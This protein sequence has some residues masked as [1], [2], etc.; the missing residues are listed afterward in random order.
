M[1]NPLHDDLALRTGNSQDSY[2]VSSGAPLDG[3]SLSPTSGAAASSPRKPSVF[4]GSLLRKMGGSARAVSGC[5]LPPGWQGYFDEW[6]NKPYYFNEGTGQW[7]TDLPQGWVGYWDEQFDQPYYYNEITGVCQWEF[8]AERADSARLAHV[9]ANGAGVVGGTSPVTAGAA[10]AGSGA[11]A[12][13]IPSH[14]VGSPATNPP[15]VSARDLAI[16]PTARERKKVSG[17]EWRMVILPRVLRPGTA[18]DA[19]KR[20]QTWYREEGC[21]GV[22]TAILLVFMIGFLLLIAALHCTPLL[23]VMANYREAR[24]YVFI[25]LPVSIIT[26]LGC[27][28]MIVR[29]SHALYR[30]TCGH[31]RTSDQVVQRLYKAKSRFK[32]VRM[33]EWFCSW[34]LTPGA[35]F[36]E[37]YEFGRQTVEVFLQIF[38]LYEFSIVGIQQ[39]ALAIYIAVMF[40]NAFASVLFLQRWRCSCIICMRGRAEADQAQDLVAVSRRIRKVV[41]AD[42]ICD[43]FYGTFPLF[44]TLL[45]YTQ[46]Y[47]EWGTTHIC[48]LVDHSGTT[49]EYDRAMFMQLPT[50]MFLFGGTSTFTIFVKMIT[51]FTPFF[52]ASS[53]LVEMVEFRS[54]AAHRKKV[55]H[56]RGRRGEGRGGRWRGGEERGS[57]AERFRQLP[58]PYEFPNDAR[59]ALTQL[60][61]SFSPRMLRFCWTPRFRGPKH[62]PSTQR[63][64]MPALQ[65]P[66]PATLRFKR[67][68]TAVSGEN[69]SSFENSNGRT[70]GANRESV[71]GGSVAKGRAGPQFRRNLTKMIEGDMEPAASAATGPAAGSASKLRTATVFSRSNPMLRPVTRRVLS[72]PVPPLAIV[73]FVLIIFGVCIFSWARLA[74]V[75]KLCFQEPWTNHCA[76]PSYPIFDLSLDG[77][78]CPC[79]HLTAVRA[80]SSRVNL[81]RDAYFPNAGP[82]QA[83]PYV[84][85]LWLFNCA[86]NN[87]HVAS[88]FRHLS[89]M[90]TLMLKAPTEIKGKLMLPEDVKPTRGGHLGSLYR[91]D[92]IAMS[93]ADLPS[94][95]PLLPNFKVLGLSHNTELKMVPPVV[96]KLKTLQN[97]V[98]DNIGLEE[99]PVWL[100]TNLTELRRFWANSNRIRSL[101]PEFGQLR[102]LFTFHMH[103]NNLTSLP[104]EFGRLTN[105]LR[106]GLA[107]N[108]LRSVPQII[109]AGGGEKL[110]LGA[111][112]GLR[113]L[114]I[115]GNNITRLPS[116]WREVVADQSPQAAVLSIEDV[117][118]L[119]QKRSNTLLVSM[120]NNSFPTAPGSS[121]L[122]WE[123]AMAEDDPL[124]VVLSMNASCNPGCEEYYW[125]PASLNAIQGDGRCDSTCNTKACHFDQGDCEGYFTDFTVPF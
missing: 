94:W 8:P 3:K 23:D 101:P 41:L 32:L 117:E 81:L 91:L 9:G 102:R 109:T 104:T 35:P 42:C 4:S 113:S 115:S 122:A 120:A 112:P 21:V 80:N 69:G 65:E 72:R 48:G 92:L 44:Y 118:S 54:W 61:S 1:Q 6:S 26:G 43:C 74:V 70:P 24:S 22:T 97:L 2:V 25:S 60:S 19:N 33:Y 59:L 53:R 114:D 16:S 84:Q 100:G 45:R 51:R 82:T 7:A 64:R 86:L 89:G 105:L 67:P 121:D 38:A 87:S 56:S 71:L 93:L 49:C 78:L 58:M 40:V 29:Y 103:G 31:G 46:V 28:L 15:P 47:G 85:N 12:A 123:V 13:G 17:Q 10:G 111:L 77:S 30:V 107:G 20:A 90:V 18:G 124:R 73:G 125:K 99:V 39:E 116:P 34:V 55:R 75:S 108:E 50:A 62:H 66:R 106:L 96:G 79:S 76:A 110:Q 88:I 57:F 119:G 98:V 27:A 36:Y 14:G 52:F 37:W 95:L 5:S 11:A 63:L 83:S 68:S